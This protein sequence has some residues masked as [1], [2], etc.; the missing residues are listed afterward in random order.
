MPMGWSTSIPLV[1]LTSLIVLPIVFS[2]SFTPG[3]LAVIAQPLILL[4]MDVLLV[5]VCNH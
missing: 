1:Y 3:E 4:T 2:K 5:M